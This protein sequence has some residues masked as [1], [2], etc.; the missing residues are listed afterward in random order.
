MNRLTGPRLRTGEKR[1]KSSTASESR[2]IRILSQIFSVEELDV[3]L[4]K[5]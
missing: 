5:R 1:R 4:A 3:Y 2:V